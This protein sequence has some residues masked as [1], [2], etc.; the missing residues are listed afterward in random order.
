MILTVENVKVRYRNGAFGVTD[1]SLKVVPGEIVALFGPNGAGKT[2]TVRAVSGFL[3]SEHTKVVAGSITLFGQNTTN[4]EPHR[5]AA[6]GLAFVP[7]RSKIFPSLT[8]S[9]NLEVM[10]RRPPRSKRAEVHAGIYEMFP[11][12]AQRRRE[13]AGRLSGGE[14]QMLA[15]ARSLM[16]EARMLIV[17]EMT[18]GLH[19]ST[20]GPLFDVIKIL[21]S[22][23]TS[24][25]FVDESSDNV[26]GVANRA[27]VLESGRSRPV[28]ITKMRASVDKD[29]MSNSPSNPPIP[30]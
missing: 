9:Q 27:Y 5:I 11:F 7:E 12:L 23:G 29:T 19:H 8:V 15:I 2:T 13:Q 6:L 28:D 22:Q 3:K 25:L 18:L 30:S 24:V 16:C 14:Q 4:M 21:A 26:L 17:D 20:H 10:A 1:V